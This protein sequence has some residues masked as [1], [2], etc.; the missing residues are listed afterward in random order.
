[1]PSFSMDNMVS[2]LPEMIV[3]SLALAVLMFDLALPK[4]EKR[5]LAYFSVAGLAIAGY[6][7]MN[8]AGLQLDT[9]YGMFV[10]DG[11]AIFF[12][13]LFY[14]AAAIAIL[15]SIGYVKGQEMDK[16]EYYALILF[17]TA[18]MMVMASGADLISIYL[19]LELMALSVY[20]L[21][22]FMR[23]SMKSN[24]AALKYF[25]L[26][27]FSSGIL[28]YGI[29]IIYGVTGTTNLAG[30]AAFIQSGQYSGPALT[31]AMILLVAGFGFKVAA[32]PFHMWVPDV[33]EGAPTSVTAF[34]SVGPKAAGFAAFLR[35]FTTALPG[36]Q[37]DWTVI[38][39]SLAIM[40][41]LIGNVV[42][43]S[44][45][46][47]KRM[48]AYSSIAHAGYAMVGFVSG[49]MQ[50]VSSVMMYLFI[51]MFMNLGAFG[52]V[53]MLRKDGVAGEELKDFAGLAKKNRTAA[54]LM[55]VFM[56]SLAGIP[57]TAGFMGKFYVFMAA[58]DAGFTWLAIIGVMMSA[59]SAYFYLR[60]IMYMYMKEPEGEF[61]LA[62]P[63]SL[64][65]AMAVAVLGVLYIG[66]A[67]AGL[68]D[69]ARI[70][71]AGMM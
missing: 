3:L 61:E 41:M 58:I 70:S 22:G 55:M 49:G 60:V 68:I 46:N 32:V 21:A 27:A 20:I 36:I 54:L 18:G 47:I 24:E 30:I 2:I 8:L 66:M 4:D 15:I 42:A 45:T 23:G 5:Y 29:A 57:P 52:M 7:T 63:L 71:I 44:Q 40:S 19:G 56:F 62:A 17:A 31:L 33:Y 69:F 9:F 37:P 10:L 48:L 11:Y 38:I 14:I 1:M 64:K 59:V 35:V 53:V 39:A 26:G 34:M 67:P 51:Y 43:I 16:G 13:V 12:K 25:L 28:L 65:L 50:G 6:Q